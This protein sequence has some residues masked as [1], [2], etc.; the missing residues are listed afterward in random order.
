MGVGFQALGFANVQ[1]KKKAPL[2]VLFLSA[3]FA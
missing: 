3:G 2:R 1:A